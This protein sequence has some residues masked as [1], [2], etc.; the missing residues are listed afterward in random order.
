MGVLKQNSNITYCYISALALLS[1]LSP[2]VA[3]P[4]PHGQQPRD[5]QAEWDRSLFEQLHNDAALSTFRLPVS[6]LERPVI[7]SVQEEQRLTVSHRVE[8]LDQ[9][10]QEASI[11]RLHELQSHTFTHSGNKSTTQLNLF[12]SQCSGPWTQKSIKN[13][14]LSW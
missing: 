1:L 7:V 14:F 10:R 13:I 2:D 11:N 6:R 3:D 5:E 9:R 8:H 4:R 12:S